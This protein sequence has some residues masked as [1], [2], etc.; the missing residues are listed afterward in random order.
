M[1]TY[2][3]KHYDE[4]AGRWCRGESGRDERAMGRPQVGHLQVGE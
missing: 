1:S 4:A 3:Y 2:L